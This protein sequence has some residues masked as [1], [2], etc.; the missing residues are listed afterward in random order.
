MPALSVVAAGGDADRTNFTCSRSPSAWSSALRRRNPSAARS[1][2]RKPPLRSWT[3]GA[4]SGRRLMAPASLHNNCEAAPWTRER[5]SSMP[6]AWAGLTPASP[7]RYRRSTATPT[8]ACRKL[9][10]RRSTTGYRPCLFLDP[11][12]TYN[13]I[14]TA[15]RSILR[16]ATAVLAQ[17][18]Q[19]TSRRHTRSPGEA[20]GGRS[21]LCHDN[22]ETDSVNRR[23]G[24]GDNSIEPPAHLITGHSYLF[25]FIGVWLTS[26]DEQLTADLQ[27]RK[28]QLGDDGEGAKR[29][30]RCH[31]E[32]FAC[33]PA[34]VVLEP[35]MD[36]RQVGEA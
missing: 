23:A 16:S 1:L 22:D 15:P 13:T 12:A 32:R 21:D 25:Q 31:I 3:C 28:S 2:L 6:D 35:C 30:S 29:P 20:G 33:R 36:H 8:T 9:E 4:S 27:E 14:L 10:Q 19:G 24:I 18:A 26:R 17:L 5:W 11:A 34:A 7:G